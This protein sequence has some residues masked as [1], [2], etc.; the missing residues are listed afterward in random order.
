MFTALLAQVPATAFYPR[1]ASVSDI[2]GSLV[3]QLQFY[4][5][6]RNDLDVLEHLLDRLDELELDQRGDIYV[7]AS[8][9]IL[10]SS[11]LE[12]TCHFGPRRRF[13]CD[14]ILGTNDVD[15]RDGF[16]RQFLHALY[17]VVAS[18]TQYHLR[19]EDQRVIGVLAREVIEGHGIGASFQRLPG[20]FK[21][22]NGVNVWVFKKIR[23]LEKTDLDTLEK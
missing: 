1:A 22:D 16:P 17:L 12:F 14:H 23:P 4:P 20:E 13:F 6:V 9:D 11:I 7:L 2:L 18:P 21:L 8:S 5:L 10:N 19:A 3:P 15:K